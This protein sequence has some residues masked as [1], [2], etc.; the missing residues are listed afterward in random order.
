MPIFEYQCD[1]GRSLDVLVRSG[2]EPVTCDEAGEA[3]DW[4]IKEGK[5]SRKVTA[6]HVGASAAPRGYNSGT[7]AEVTSTGCGHCGQAPGSGES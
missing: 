3:S 7:G 2:R 1:C 6:A 5:L 4:C